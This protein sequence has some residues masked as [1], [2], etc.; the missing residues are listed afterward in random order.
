MPICGIVPEIGLITDFQYSVWFSIVDCGFWVLWTGKPFN[1]ALSKKQR[2]SS[3][4][5]GVN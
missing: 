3:N 5:E 4:R 1:I 2:D